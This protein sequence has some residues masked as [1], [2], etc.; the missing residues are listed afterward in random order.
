MA[1]S[2]MQVFNTYFM[3]A[4]IETLGQQIERFNAASNG[5]IRLTT[6]GFDGDFI[7]ESFFQAI[8]TAQ[9]RVDRYQNNYDQAA[10]DLTQEKNI[11]VKVAG[12]FGPIRYEPSQMTWLRQPSARGIE[13]ASRNFAEAMLQD[14]LNT[15]IAALVGA[16]GN[17]GTDTTETNG[18]GNVTYATL[19]SA[20]AKFG[21]RSMDIAANVMDGVQYHTLIG[22][23]LANSAE[24]FNYGAVTIVDILGK[25]VIVTDAPALRTSGTGAVARV[26]GLVRDAAIVSDGGDVISNIQTVNGKERIETTMQVDYTFGLRLKGYAWDTSTGG[27]S[28]TDNALATGSN[29]DKVVTDIKHTAGVMA[30]G[31]A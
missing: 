1:L 15:A 13:V 17:Q 8:H 20:H 9:R 14:Q 30:V 6:E 23:N 18:S 16:I 26:L 21:D 7:Q 11:G 27:K 28:P 31:N 25:A 22:Q 10:T 29:W 12:G 24:L 4:I 19:N 3:P 2:D 5:S